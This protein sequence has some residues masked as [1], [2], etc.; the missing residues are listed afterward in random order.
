[1]KPQVRFLSDELI[2]RILDEAYKLLAT[3]GVE[4]QH[5][6]IPKRLADAGCAIDADSGRVLMPR[7][8]VEAAVK[9]APTGR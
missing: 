6:S 9:S 2:T 1:M 8:I 3:K 7:G 4:I 5:E